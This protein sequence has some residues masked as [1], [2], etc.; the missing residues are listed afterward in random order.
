[1]AISTCF[2]S[3]LLI[4]TLTHTHI[5]TAPP[6]GLEG[7]DDVCDVELCLQVELDS[8]VFLAV[9]SLP[10]SHSLA[11]TWGC[12]VWLPPVDDAGYV[13][14]LLLRIM[15]VNKYTNTPCAPLRKCIMYTNTPR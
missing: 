8:D 1:M 9:W 5:R 10:P 2:H 13:V 12:V 3:I 4:V 6:E 11:T 7:N 14:R 15:C